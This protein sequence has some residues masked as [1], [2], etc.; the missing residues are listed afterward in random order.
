VSRILVI[1]GTFAASGLVAADRHVD[2]R[3]LVAYLEREGVQHFSRTSFAILQESSR[4]QVV[5][6]PGL[7]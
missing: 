1:G 4:R 2:P 7:S 6:R 3:E 5:R